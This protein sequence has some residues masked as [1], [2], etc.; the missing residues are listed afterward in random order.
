MAGVS[1]VGRNRERAVRRPDGARDEPGFVRVCPGKFR[2][3]PLG[4]F[5]G[6]EVDL[7]HEA[8]QGIVGLRDGV[9]VESVGLNDIAP[10]LEKG[11]VNLPDNFRLGEGKEIVVSLQIARVI[12]EPIPAKI[13]LFEIVALNHGARGAVQHH[14]S[15]FQN[16]SEL[17][18]R[19]LVGFPVSRAR[20]IFRSGLRSM[21]SKRLNFP[22]QQ[23]R[24]QPSYFG[25]FSRIG[26]TDG[27]APRWRPVEGNKIRAPSGPLWHD[28]R[29]EL[30]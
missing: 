12:P 26:E 23:E 15:L 22:T 4:D 27:A 16:R 30:F 18:N 9:R 20:Q 10:N 3:E 21:D 8:L 25:Q 29:P 5:R 2:A 1:H 14:D 24:A 17:F 13:R 7:I 6:L 28:L 19:H 11:V